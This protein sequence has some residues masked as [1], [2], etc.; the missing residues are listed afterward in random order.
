MGISSSISLPTSLFISSLVY[1]PRPVC[2]TRSYEMFRFAV[3]LL[4]AYAFFAMALAAPIVDLAGLGEL[5]SL[6]SYYTTVG[7]SFQN[8]SWHLLILRKKSQST[9][10]YVGQG[11]CGAWSKNSDHI[12]A[13]GA[14]H[15]GTGGHCGQYI[16]VE[17]SHSQGLRT[18]TIINPASRIQI[19]RNQCMRWFWTNVKVVQA[20]IVSVSAQAIWHHCLMTHGSYLV[21]IC[22]PVPSRR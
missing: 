1:L 10:F 5:A 4:C 14:N 2:L 19:P 15:Y 3:S 6:T 17:V 16:Y 12:V 20:L 8:P 22:L 18:R 11:A 7:F 13:F 9:Y 21:Q